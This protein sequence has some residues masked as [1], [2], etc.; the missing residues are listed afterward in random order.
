[1]NL[2]QKPVARA[3]MKRFVNS[4]QCGSESF[5][6]S[7]ADCFDGRVFERKGL[8]AVFTDEKMLLQGSTFGLGKPAKGVE[9]KCFCGDVVGGQGLLSSHGSWSPALESPGAQSAPQPT[10]KQSEEQQRHN[11]HDPMVARESLG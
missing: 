8:L 3:E 7:F 9:F 10:Q 2:K 4:G 11:M 5:S 6:Q 1:V